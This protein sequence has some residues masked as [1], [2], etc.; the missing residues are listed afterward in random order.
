M[1]FLIIVEHAESLYFADIY[2][3]R[4][5]HIA[6]VKRTDIQALKR[7]VLIVRTVQDKIP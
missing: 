4:Q 3:S 5:F 6:S 2:Q 7:K 1:R